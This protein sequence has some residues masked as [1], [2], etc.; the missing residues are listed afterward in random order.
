MN[1]S[2]QNGRFEDISDRLMNSYDLI[3]GEERYEIADLEIYYYGEITREGEIFAHYDP[4]FQQIIHNNTK[5]RNTN[6]FILTRSKFYIYI[7]DELGYGAV[8]INAIRSR[9]LHTIIDGKRAVAQKILKYTQSSEQNTELFFKCK[10]EYKKLLASPR[11][12]LCETK[13]PDLTFAMKNY[14]FTNLCCC[15]KLKKGNHLLKL[16]EH[17]NIFKDNSIPFEEK[18][19]LL[20]KLETENTSLFSWLQSYSKGMFHDA[21]YFSNLSMSIISHQCELYGFVNR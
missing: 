20:K 15:E 17:R 21:K 9:D 13:N 16:A 12:G 8:L 3:L 2:L 4:Y 7:D 1:L 18:V 10:K 11:K 5:A 14:R 6:K 19:I